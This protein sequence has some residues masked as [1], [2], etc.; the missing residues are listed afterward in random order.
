MADVYRIGVAIGMTD[1]ASQVLQALGRNLL[2]LNLKIKDIEGGLNRIKIAALGL[3]GVF[4]GRAIIEGW[5]NAAEAGAKLQAAQIA[6]TNAGMTHLEVVQETARAYQSMS[7]VKGPDIVERINALRELR[8]IVGAGPGGHDYREIN[9]LLPNYLKVRELVGDKG[10][11]DLFRTVEQQGGARFK[12]DGSF[13]QARF[14]K[15]VDAALR[16]IQAGGGNITPRDLLN[17]MQMASTTARGMDPDAFWNTMMTPI[18]EMGGH[19]AGTA[20]TALSRALFGGI[21]PERNARELDR[22]GLYNPG[23]VRVLPHI[24]KEERA[25]LIKQGYTIGRGGVVTVGA[26]ALRGEKEL[27]DPTQGIF[28]WIKDVF[29]PRLKADYEKN[30]ASKPGNTETFD[31]YLRDEMYKALPTETARR[32][33]ALLTAQTQSA[34]RDQTMRGQAPGLTAYDTA[35][36]GFD[37]QVENIKRAWSSL[38]ETLGLPAAQDGARILKAIAG[39]LDAVTQWAARNPNAAQYLE[40][41]A[42]GIGAVIA[43]SGTAAIAG[44]ALG[45]LAAGIKLLAGSLLPFGA[46]GAAKMA[47]EGAAGEIATLTA[48]GG[49][50][51]IALLVTR[52]G[53][54]GLAIGGAIL[55]L[56]AVD[57]IGPD[58]PHP[59]INAHGQGYSG[60]S[61][62]DAGAPPPHDSGWGVFNGLGSRIQQ[63]WSESQKHPTHG[64]ARG[65][66]S[67]INP[68]A[69]ESGSDMV[70]LQP[71]TIINQ[72]DG[73]QIGRHVDTYQT[74]RAA[75]PSSSGSLVDPVEVPLRPGMQVVNL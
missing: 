47:A 12:A 42:F 16:T 50:G 15:Y 53:V 70:H 68:T 61:P 33:V 29:L 63:G 7:E 18:L 13:D 44:A 36:Q 62:A 3:G 73:N 28:P 35:Q 71:I 1:N 11:N 49:P 69:Y 19:R 39:G 45:P 65:I 4:A 38:M 2:G 25:E 26:G 64:N 10:A 51:S 5:S 8:G 55:A 74:R 20:G 46:G 17:V 67:A 59:N 22:L 27:N 66:G 58:N 37:K 32:F 41:F 14:E 23:A 6:M 57:S 24:T 40:R 43:V 75:R 9:A 72:I 52:L 30:V 60:R 56:K 54:L 48:E 31:A 34:Q 21:M